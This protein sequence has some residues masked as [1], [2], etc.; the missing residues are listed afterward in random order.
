M[1]DGGGI[2]KS[3]IPCN[4]DRKSGKKSTSALSC[5]LS[6]GELIVRNVLIA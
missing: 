2:L 4:L 6:L 5:Y 1:Q 3:K